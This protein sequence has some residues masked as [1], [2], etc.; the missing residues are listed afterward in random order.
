[1]YGTEFD[2][3]SD[4]KALKE[5]TDDVIMNRT[6]NLCKIHSQMIVEIKKLI[7]ENRDPLKK[8]LKTL[9]EKNIYV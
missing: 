7:K 9:K 4:P 2:F 8:Y 5:S 6:S 3:I 1:M